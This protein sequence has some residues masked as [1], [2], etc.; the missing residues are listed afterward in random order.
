M[1]KVARFV[2]IIVILEIVIFTSDI[3]EKRAVQKCMEAG[4]DYS[5]CMDVK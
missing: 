5:Y 2:V 4:N 3:I 1:Q